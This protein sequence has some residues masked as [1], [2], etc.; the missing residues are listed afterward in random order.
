[1][2]IP[3][4]LI[5]KLLNHLTGWLVC[6]CVTPPISPL[7]PPG[8]LSPGAGRWDV[9]LRHPPQS[10]GSSHSTP[11]PSCA[12]QSGNAG[13]R[14]GPTRLGPAE[15]GTIRREITVEHL[16]DLANP[17]VVCLQALNGHPPRY[18]VSLGLLKIIIIHL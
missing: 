3:N 4:Y 9:C 5:V 15:R 6:L 17:C 2:M 18:L 13:D 1:M 10:P 12:P 16:S 11:E 8:I 14:T 7:P